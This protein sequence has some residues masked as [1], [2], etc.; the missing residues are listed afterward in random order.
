MR[1]II[2]SLNSCL[3]TLDKLTVT[4]LNQCCIVAAITEELKA[5]IV[6]LEN[7]AGGKHDKES[8]NGDLPAEG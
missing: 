3:V 5:D 1:E 6:R 7:I 8:R 4:G 2:A